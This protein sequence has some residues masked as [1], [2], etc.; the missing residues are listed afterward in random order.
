M[1]TA[2]L[3]LST[4]LACAGLAACATY[5]ESRSEVSVEEDETMI[6]GNLVYRERIALRPGSTATVTLEDVSRADAPSRTI[7]TR[8]IQ[9]DGRQ[10][11][12][13]FTIGVDADELSA[14][15]R[16]SLRATIHGPDGNLA[17]TTDTAR[18]FDPS[19]G[20]QDFGDVTLVQVRGGGNSDER[21]EVAYRCGD[22]NV[23]VTYA[24][25]GVIFRFD[26]REFR[27][28]RMPSGSGGKYVNGTSGQ[29][30]Y[31][32][33]WEKGDN[34]QLQ[35]GDRD[36]PEC[37]R[38]TSS[39]GILRLGHEWVVEDIDDRGIIDSS[40]VTV[41]FSVDGRISGRASCNDYSGSYRVDGAN[42]IVSDRLAVTRKLCAPALMNQEERFLSTLTQTSN[43]S[44][45]ASGSLLLASDNEG[46]L[47]AR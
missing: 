39:A 9:L 22:T 38:V 25:N 16:Y 44:R 13:P 6:T 37:T 41:T 23:D 10:V 21:N 40:R 45:D 20:D 26:N 19:A 15:G 43:I 2:T 46:S 4:V 14:R 12:I 18:L 8:T 33:F 36:Y 24:E 42:L 11:P 5:A 30:N 32:L 28:R 47:R 31:V 35:F 27:L 3:L 1:K 17:W 7:A 29:S 34:A